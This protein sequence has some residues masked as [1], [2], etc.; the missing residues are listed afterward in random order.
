MRREDLPLVWIALA[1]WGVLV[2]ASALM[3]GLDS[4]ASRPATIVL[5][6]NEKPA[7]ANPGGRETGDPFAD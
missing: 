2:L 6:P 4:I 5:L 1:I 7:R 3:M